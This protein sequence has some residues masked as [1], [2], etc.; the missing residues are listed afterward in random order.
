MDEQLP[1]GARVVAEGAQHAT[2]HHRHPRLVDPARGHALVLRLDDH[3]HAARIEHLLDRVGDLRGQLFLDLQPLGI[4]V[5]QPGQLADAHHAPVRQIGHVGAPDDR[6]HVVLAIALQPDVAQQHDLVVAV[7]LLERALEQGRR[8]DVVAGE[9]LLVGTHH[10]RRAC[11]ADPRGRGRRRPI[12]TACAPPLPPPRASAGDAVPAAA[13]E[14]GRRRR[15]DIHRSSILQAR[16]AL[17]WRLALRLQV[18]TGNALSARC[19]SWWGLSRL[20]AGIATSKVSPEST[21]TMW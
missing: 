14:T 4:G 5:D 2:G 6:H 21:S 19:R 17:S 3:R 1:A 11:R 13:G 8:I 18:R 16:P 9:E 10:P 15:G 7:G 20:K 12:T